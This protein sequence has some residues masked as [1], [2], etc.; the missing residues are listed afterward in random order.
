MNPNSEKK[1]K[2]IN[3]ILLKNRVFTEKDDLIEIY[4]DLLKTCKAAKEFYD[5]F[6]DFYND[7]VLLTGERF[8]ELQISKNAEILEDMRKE[9]N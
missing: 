8:V 1:P 6:N 2:D 9:F 4:I 5:L 7:V 3:M